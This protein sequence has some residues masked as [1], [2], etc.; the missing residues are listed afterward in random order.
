LR[1]LD[2]EFGD[3]EFGDLEFGDL[4]FEETCKSARD[5]L[6]IIYYNMIKIY[7]LFL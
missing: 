1:V 4:D 5:N 3:F 6:S 7:Y 2:F